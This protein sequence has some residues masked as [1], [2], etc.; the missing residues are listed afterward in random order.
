MHG[1]PNSAP[2]SQEL[3]QTCPPRAVSD[4]ELYRGAR[5]TEL[6]TQERDQITANANAPAAAAPTMGATAV[7]SAE[8]LDPGRERRPLESYFQEIRRAGGDRVHLSLDPVPLQDVPRL[9]AGCDIGLVFYRADLGPN[10]TLIA[11]ASGK[12]AYYLKCGLPVI[13][14][15][16]PGLVRVVDGYQ[17]GIC[18]PAVTGVAD[19]I[20]TILSDYER[21][22]SN[23]RRCFEEAYEFDRFFAQVLSRVEDSCAHSE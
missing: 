4:P 10:F 20:R 22:Q 17:C 18:V 12:L 7:V 6:K 21:Y 8:E 5:G 3:F 11:G 15:D 23:A 19:A 1:Q 13:C 14:I 16:F 2:T 9:V